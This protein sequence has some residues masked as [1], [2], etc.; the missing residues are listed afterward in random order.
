MIQF[1]AIVNSSFWW[2]GWHL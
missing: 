1:V 2:F